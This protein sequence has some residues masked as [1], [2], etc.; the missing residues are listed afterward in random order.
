M[1]TIWIV[2]QYATFPYRGVTCRHFM[3]ARE[4]AK[5]GYSVTIIA[6]SGHY[7]H[8]KRPEYTGL[9]NSEIIEDVKFVWLKTPV[10]EQNQQLRRGLGWVIFLFNLLL[11]RST[12]K[13]KPD[14]IIH[15]SP[16]LIPFLGSYFLS[17]RNNSKILFEFRD[18][19]PLTFI[20]IANYSSFH[21]VVFIQGW[22]EKF[23][24]KKSDACLSSMEFGSLRLKEL[25][26][27]TNKFY[28]LPN[29]V[30]YE[31]FD[32]STDIIRSSDKFVFGYI[33]SHGNANAL[34]TIVDAAKYLTDYPI[35]I[36]MIGDGAE[37]I[38][39]QE[40]AKL[41]LLDN[42]TFAVRVNKQEVPSILKSVD[43]FLISWHDSSIYRYGT[44]ANK[45]AEYFAAGKPVV[46]AYSGAGDHVEKFKAGITVPA[47]DAEAM[48][49]AMIKIAT[50][51]EQEI[52]NYSINAKKAAYENF[53]F[54][55]LAKRLIKMLNEL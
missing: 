46:Q 22:I 33:G 36:I 41:L 52:E 14:V 16:S 30:V 24:I 19:W 48:A 31:D 37:R 4:L 7:F 20:K 42:I 10:Y 12:N 43:G 47:G 45:L 51:D 35:H 3:L 13:S 15:S 49:G 28:W 2:N 40:R 26:I 11:L 53:T 55:S 25:G 5:Q 34:G 38:K 1:K 29:G 17:W 27:N 23:A 6:G 44:S 21:P 18:V 50:A 54:K 32:A 8:N 39:L 9:N